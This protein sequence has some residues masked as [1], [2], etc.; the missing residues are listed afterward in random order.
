MT[1]GVDGMA[2]RSCAVESRSRL[3]VATRTC[4]CMSGRAL[5]CRDI[6]RH[7]DGGRSCLAR[8]GQPMAGKRGQ[9]VRLH[10]IGCQ[11]GRK[12]KG[13]KSNVHPVVVVVVLLE[14]P[15][16]SVAVSCQLQ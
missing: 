8:R 11:W 13:E 7:V 6:E 12:A 3:P 5:S 10:D 14:T 1:V 2:Q 16:H 9:G 15:L 4:T